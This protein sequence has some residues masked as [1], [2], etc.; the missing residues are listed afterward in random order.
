MYISYNSVIQF[1]NNQKVWFVLE[2]YYSI[3]KLSKSVTSKFR[4]LISGVV[5]SYLIP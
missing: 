1:V 3:D 5:F 2:S 4:G